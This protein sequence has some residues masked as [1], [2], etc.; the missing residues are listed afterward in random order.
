MNHYYLVPDGDRWRIRGEDSDRCLMDFATK[1]EA[2]ERCSQL[3]QNQHGSLRIHRADGT[4]EEERTFPSSAE[5]VK[6]KEYCSLPQV[7]EVLNITNRDFVS[8]CAH[9][10]ALEAASGRFVRVSPEKP[11]A[12]TAESVRTPRSYP[13]PPSYRCILGALSEGS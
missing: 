7:L 10:S 11:C 6:T 4:L 12:Q 3:M 1:E 2:V 5:P 9:S 13:L 8:T